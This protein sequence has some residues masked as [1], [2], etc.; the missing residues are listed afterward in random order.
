MIAAVLFDLDETLL[1]RT[2]S[3]VDFL[4]DQHRRFEKRLGSAAFGA[5]RDKFL[6]LDARGRVH[7]SLVYPAILA[8]FGGD[9]TVAD[10]LL[11]DYQ[12]RCC[13][14]A[15][16]FP[17]M[18]DTLSTIRSKGLAIGIVTNG[19]AEFQWRHIDA[20][21]LRELVDAVLISEVEGLRKPEKALFVRAAA[22]LNVAPTKCLFVG[23]NPTADILGA[24]AAGM[25][26]AWFR[27]GMTWPT[28][29][30]GPPGAVINALS[31]VPKLIDEFEDLP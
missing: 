28:E 20:L 26:T 12:Q 18:A 29:F 2:N 15:R 1:D 9:S 4:V 16:P 27:C 24:H 23:D 11:A 31:E 22:R 14:Y 8:S 6:T 5:W 7:K 13:Q 25:K 17:G 10:E 21:S 3:L 30:E 19:E